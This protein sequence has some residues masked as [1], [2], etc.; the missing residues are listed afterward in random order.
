M[1]RLAGNKRKNSSRSNSSSSRSSSSNGGKQAKVEL[2]PRAE[3]PI[4]ADVRAD[5]I[6]MNFSGKRQKISADIAAV[7]ENQVGIRQEQA[8]QNAMLK[9][10]YKVVGQFITQYKCS[11][12]PI[13]TNS[14]KGSTSS[15]SSCYI[16]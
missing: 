3:E 5:G 7:L 16:P 9:Q 12:N 2:L 13:D 1:A 6:H 8:R 15:L 4:R 10:L 14:H 11:V